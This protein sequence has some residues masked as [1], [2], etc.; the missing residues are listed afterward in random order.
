MRW[1]LKLSELGFIVEHR[2]GSKI[3]HV[4]SLSRHVSAVMQEGCLDRLNILR[5][6]AK[7]ELSLSKHSGIYSSRSEF[8]WM[9]VLC[10]SASPVTN[11]SW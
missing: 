9:M 11:I 4:D 10:T 1:G 5:E 7:D 6:Q 8:F 2:A 3:G